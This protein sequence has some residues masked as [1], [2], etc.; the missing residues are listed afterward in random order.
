M[1]DQI[2]VYEVSFGKWLAI[3]CEGEMRGRPQDP[4]PSHCK[5]KKKNSDFKKRGIHSVSTSL[6]YVI[7]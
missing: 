5:H 6:I 2:N 3:K 1:K 7:F 4:N